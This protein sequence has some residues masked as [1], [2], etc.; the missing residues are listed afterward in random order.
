MKRM[1][2]II[3]SIILVVFVLSACES[4]CERQMRIDGPSY[5]CTF[6]YKFPEG[7]D[8]SNN[9]MITVRYDGRDT[10]FESFYEGYRPIPLH[11]GYYMDGPISKQTGSLDYYYLTIT[12]DD[13]EQGTVP[14]EWKSHW[15]EYIVPCWRVTNIYCPYDEVYCNEFCDCDDE[16]CGYL[17]S[18][19][20]NEDIT[21]HT[22]IVEDI[23][24]DTNILNQWID[25]EKIIFHMSGGP[26]K[27]AW[28]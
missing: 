4:K 19:L 23:H 7:R 17:H 5:A 6:V 18:E 22:P 3:P 13:I 24:I 16:P 1:S 12:Y 28:R 27:D 10:L 20:Y 11:N 15:K 8:L 14:P 9:I 2:Y 21:L 25:N 26:K